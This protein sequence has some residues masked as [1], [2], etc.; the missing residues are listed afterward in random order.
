MD[1]IIAEV[2]SSEFWIGVLLGNLLLVGGI[3]Y[4]IM[5]VNNINSQSRE[6]NNHP[7]DKK[8]S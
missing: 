6:S 1:S 5:S 3:M 4:L 2:T 8:R 7:Q